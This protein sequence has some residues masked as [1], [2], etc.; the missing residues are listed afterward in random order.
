MVL[1]LLTGTFIRSLDDKQRFAIPKPLREGFGQ[2]SDL[3]LYLAPGTD[4]SLSLYSEESFTQLANQL[5]NHSPNAQE[6]RAFSRLF[7][8]QAQRVDVDRQGRVR[9]PSDLAQWAALDKEIILLGVRD[10]LEVWNPERWESYLSDK[11][12][13]Y[14]A[15]AESAFARSPSPPLPQRSRSEANDP[16]VDSSAGTDEFRPPQPR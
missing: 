6:T 3:V 13:Q 14:D 7:Y 11:Q 12:P 16:V 9:L 2:S 8:A 5:G 10:H 15:L 4:R 1:M